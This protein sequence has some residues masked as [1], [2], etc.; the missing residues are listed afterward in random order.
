MSEIQRDVQFGSG[1]AQDTLAPEAGV[2]QE[3]AITGRTPW[4]LARARLRRDK[5]TM[6]VLAVLA[7]AIVLAILAPILSII[8]VLDPETFHPE[9]I[10]GNTGGLP[11]DGGGGLSLQHPLGVE[12]G[13]GRDVLS[14][15][16]LG[17]TFSMT[18]ALS[19]TLITVVLGTVMGLVAGLLGGKTDFFISRIMDM[20]L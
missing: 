3:K 12:P 1:T 20:V 11:L 5:I 4:Q 8:G 6:V 13:T 15:I 16:A 7:L 10:D 18:V 14:R 19:A 2:T 17:M 9:L